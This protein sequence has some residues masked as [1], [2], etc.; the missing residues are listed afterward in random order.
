MESFERIAKFADKVF[1]GSLVD[2]LLGFG[3]KFL[4]QYNFFDDN[5]KFHE[6]CKSP[7]FQQSS[8]FI[9]QLFMFSPNGSNSCSFFTILKLN[10]DEFG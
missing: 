7:F 9:L 5:S 6:C 2:V 4:L 1:T 8:S 10:N 3:I